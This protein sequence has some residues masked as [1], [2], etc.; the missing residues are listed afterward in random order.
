MPI[1]MDY[2]ES[3]ASSSFIQ[4]SAAG[5]RIASSNHPPFVT[6]GAQRAMQKLG[7]LMA[8]DESSANPSPARQSP[9]E[10]TREIA[11]A[12]GGRLNLDSLSD[13]DGDED[14]IMDD[15]SDAVYY[16]E[17]PPY[18]L[19]VSTLPTGLCYD[20][21]MRYHAEVAINESSYHPEDPRRIYYIYKELCEAGL[22]DD[23]RSRRPVVRQPLFRIDAREATEDECCLIHTR[24]H[25]E[26][27]K[28]TSGE[29]QP[30]ELPIPSELT[31]L[32]LDNDELIELS[33][34]PHL[35]SIYFNKLSYFSAKLSAGGA[36]ETCRAVFQGK[37]KNAIAV[38]RPPGHHAE[39]S[40]TMGFCLFNN[41]CIASRVCQKE[42]QEKCRKILILDW[43]WY[44][45]TLSLRIG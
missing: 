7:S 5:K 11:N 26:F 8:F 16:D 30:S 18:G 3:S 21:R 23:L 10:S 32:E 35:D 1:D 31:T 38:I 34:A 13:E 6:N 24:K 33:E 14:S 12:M 36:I 28:H 40:S 15:A 17:M 37:V 45:S 43:Y 39:V 27:V 22:V 29:Y 44:F 25:Y 2:N 42:F 4:S 20:D 19:P 9:V 41:T